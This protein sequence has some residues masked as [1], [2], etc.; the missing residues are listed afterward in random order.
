MTSDFSQ[1]DGVAL[2]KMVRSGDLDPLDLLRSTLSAIDRVNPALNAVIH[3]MDEEAHRVANY[4][5]NELA[6]GRADNVPFCGVPFLLKDLLAEY[7]GAPFNEG[8]RAL[9]DNVS[10]IDTELV[11][12]MKAAGLVVCGKT[13]TPEFGGSPVTE[14]EL[15]G[16][17]RN[18]WNLEHTP[19]GSS[20]GSAAMVAAGVVPMAHANDGG[21]SIRIPAACCGLFGMKPTRGRNPLGPLFGDLGGGIIYEHV[22]SRTVR[23]SAAMLDATAGPE[24]GEPYG[25]PPVVRP[26]S[27]EVLREPGK[28]RIGFINRLPFG[29][30]E[31][32]KP[33]EECVAG[34]EATA[35][36]CAALGHEVVDVDAD[37]FA[38][39]DMPAVFGPR[40]GGFTAHV[41]RYWAR[42][43]GRELTR[44]DVEDA[45]WDWYQ[46]ALNSNPAE[47]LEAVEIAQGFSRRV[48]RWY[49]DGGFDVLLTPT[50]AVPPVRIGAFAPSDDAPGQWLL[51]ILNFVAFTYAYNLTGQPAMS[52]PLVQSS[53]GLPIGMQF[54]G[55]FGDE[56]TLFRLAAQLEQA[57]PWIGRLPT[58][59]C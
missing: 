22:V 26:Y 14:P 37:T 7:A 44:E 54:V 34:V 40:F 48:A 35:K 38:Q 11:V 12:R 20:G 29:W 19:G 32:T 47:Y 23:D 39:P 27:E 53:G 52:V 33:H 2:G 21:G 55:R 13:N 41:M 42:V 57:H 45:T 8:C 58:V 49:E 1:Y 3:R 43:L 17:T 10:Q 30:H 9:R 5:R 36:Q 6:A 56:A 15:H 59:H 31:T 50:L 4:W 46:G 16:V 24:V 18:P 51:D 25:L 28:L